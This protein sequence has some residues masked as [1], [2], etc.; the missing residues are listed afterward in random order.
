M[1]TEGKPD[2]PPARQPWRGLGAWNLYFLLKFGLLWAGVLNFHPLPNI[3]FAAAL[4]LP[5]SGKWLP[6][7]RQAV[8]IPF[9]AGLLYYDTWLP[10]VSRL[11]EAMQDVAGFSA[12]YLIEMTARAVN[13]DMAA[14]ALALWVAYLFLAQWLRL[15]VFTVLALAYLAL[16]NIP[17]PPDTGN[18]AQAAATGRSTTSTAQA[19]TD[20]APPSQTSP[21]SADA[22]TGTTVVAKDALDQS[23]P[24]TDDNLNAYLQAFYRQQS[25]RK[26]AFPENA[27]D[28][29]AFDVLILNICSLSWSDLDEV[30]LRDHPLFGKMDIVFKNFNSA[31]SYSGPASLRLLRASCGQTPH[32]QLYQDPS[33]DCYLFENLKALGY[34]VD[35]ALNHNGEYQGFLEA[36]R[37]Q[38]Q[39]PAL[40]GDQDTSQRALV[41]FDGSPIWRDIDVLTQ[42]RQHRESAAA[43]RAALFYNSI[44]LHD[45]NRFIKPDGGTLRA[46]YQPRAQMLLDE[47]ASFVGQLEREG[48][49]TLLMLV[50]EHGAALHGDRIQISGMREIPS[51]DITHIPVAIKLIGA[52]SKPQGHPLLV[53]QSSSYLALSELL[54]RLLREHAFS[55]TNLNLEALVTDLPETAEVSEN[56][57]AVVMR[58]RDRPYIRLADSGWQPYPQ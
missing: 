5:L 35:L 47:L 30:Q 37:A 42:W 50:P 1:Q 23:A 36:I 9:G 54:A 20:G 15:S 43:T 49:P 44:T 16:P 34:T 58:Y 51:P 56:Q 10:P 14:A 45:G 27:A 22:P 8:A 25:Q 48:R 24:P 55:S 2:A 21:D 40:I 19:P 28:A 33:P 3:A 57:S 52:K 53:T 41:A 18:V 29:D 13:W 6:R 38:G 26:T 31:T 4:V 39:M 17:L 32:A 12:D 11:A 46:S 7:L